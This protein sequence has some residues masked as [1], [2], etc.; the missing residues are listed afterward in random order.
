MKRDHG[1]VFLPMRDVSAMAKSLG[2]SMPQPARGRE[3]FQ[4]FTI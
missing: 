1:P 4:H 3:R 2:L